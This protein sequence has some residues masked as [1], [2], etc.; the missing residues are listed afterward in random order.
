MKVKV[1]FRDGSW[2]LGHRSWWYGWIETWWTRQYK[3]LDGSEEF[4]G[5][6]GKRITVHY[7]DYK[8]LV[9]G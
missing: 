1:V 3:V 7:N 8:Y 4:K 5:L 2:F 9:Q 6:V